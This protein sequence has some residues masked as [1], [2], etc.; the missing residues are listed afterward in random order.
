ME[1]GAVL[2][3]EGDD[4]LVFEELEKVGDAFFAEGPVVAARVLSVCSLKGGRGGLRLA[5]TEKALQH[6]LESPFLAVLGAGLELFQ[7]S[8]GLGQQRVVLLLFVWPKGDSV[9]VLGLGWKFEV[10]KRH[11][12]LAS[13]A[14]VIHQR[15][16]QAF[17]AGIT[18]GQRPRDDRVENLRLLDTARDVEEL[19]QRMEIL[20]AVDT[21]KELAFTSN[22]SA[23]NTYMGVPDR[24]HLD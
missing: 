1:E 6:A 2:V 5:E 12:F 11:V 13:Q 7:S 21:T 10:D 4:V 20:D 15:L 8:L 23:R 14:E 3:G 9:D 16:Q 18:L 22:D 17:S 24:T 19:E